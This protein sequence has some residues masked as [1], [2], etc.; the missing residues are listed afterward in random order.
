M[1]SIQDIKAQL[2]G[3]KRYGSGLVGVFVGGTSGIGESTAREFV[4]YAVKPRIYLVGRSQEQADLLK[5]EFQALNPESQI[6]FIKSDVAQL[7]NVDAVCE[8][9]K[10]KDDKIN[11]LCLSAGIMTLKG[12]DETP[13]GL[14]KKLSLHYYSRLRFTQNLLPLLNNAANSSGD[15]SVK[16]LARVLS[17]LGATLESPVNLK[18]LDLKTTYSISNAANHAITMTTLSFHKLAQSNPGVT[19]IHSQP[20]GVNTNLLRTFPGWVKFAFDKTAWMLKPWMVPIQESGERHVWAS[21]NDEFGREKVVLVWQDSKAHTNPK[22]DAMMKDVTMD[23][24]FEHTEDVFR[25][26]CKE[27]GKF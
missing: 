21:T 2:T 23:K 9:I 13:E 26:V 27:D 12:R 11:L 10:A 5:E 25:K 24:V 8:E 17:V 19:F 1:V 14:D 20:G 15:I 6:N 16:P 3:L 18:D 22:V 7:R 4:R